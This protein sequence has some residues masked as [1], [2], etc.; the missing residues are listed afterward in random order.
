MLVS[1]AD[2]VCRLVLPPPT[3]PAGHPN[4][5]SEGIYTPAFPIMRSLV[6]LLVSGALHQFLSLF[7][8]R[9]LSAVRP[10][11]SLT[12]FLTGP[13]MQFFLL[14]G[15]GIIVEALVIGIYSGRRPPA[16]AKGS[17]E[18]GGVVRSSNA[19]RYIG[20]LWV[21]AWISFTVQRHMNACVELALMRDAYYNPRKFDLNPP[22]MW[23]WL[24]A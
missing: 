12:S 9:S 13:D 16:T 18:V 17:Q 1:H 14:Q 8:P 11:A 2:V 7:T 19:V 4:T 5:N 3:S 20:Y 6:A 21:V 10:P 24:K 22:E 23:R 15:V